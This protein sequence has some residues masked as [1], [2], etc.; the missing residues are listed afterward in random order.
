LRDKP[1]FASIA[2]ELIDFLGDSPLVIHNAGFDLGFLNAELRNVGKQ[3]ISRDRIVDTLLLARTKHPSGPNR[4]DDLALRYKVRVPKR[5]RPNALKDAK[6][7]AEIYAKLLV[8]RGD[9]FDPG[10]VFDPNYEEAVRRIATA[11]RKGSEKL[12]LA[13]LHDLERLPPEISELTAL[14][15][16][17]LGGFIESTK[18]VDL[19]AL[20]GLV[21]LERLHLGRT[22]V[23]SVVPLTRLKKLSN[24]NLSETRVSD[25]SSLSKL[26]NLSRLNLYRTRVTDLEPLSASSKLRHLDIR[27][28]KIS[29]LGPLANVLTLIAS[30]NAKPAEDGILFSPEQIADPI[31]G[32]MA[33][34]RNPQRTREVIVYLR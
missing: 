13:N 34:L 29:N 11:K 1:T 9:L 12:S 6:I 14:R 17:T 18:I 33:R 15:S 24:L 7:L 21:N 30:P 32:A 22:R 16:L 19:E 28:S 31:V 10:R 2:D 5:T 3:L 23:T 27:K 4:L 26:S 8:D 20:S 25:I